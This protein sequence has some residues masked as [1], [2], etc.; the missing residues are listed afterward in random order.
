MSSVSL[1]SFLF[2]DYLSLLL[3]KVWVLPERGGFYLIHTV[4]LG[5]VDPTKGQWKVH[6]GV[7]RVLSRERDRPSLECRLDISPGGR[8]GCRELRDRDRCERPFGTRVCRV[9]PFFPFVFFRPYV[10][11]EL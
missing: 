5:R 3:I 9:R 2:S 4:D 11:S 1:S 8:G 6:N 10:V 7:L